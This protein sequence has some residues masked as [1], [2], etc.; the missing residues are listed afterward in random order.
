MGGGGGVEIVFGVVIMIIS[1]S[2]VDLMIVMILV[3]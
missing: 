2:L 1:K 3:I